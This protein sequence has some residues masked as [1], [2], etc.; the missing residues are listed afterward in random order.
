MDSICGC[1]SVG[2]IP[3]GASDPYALRRQSIGI[4]QI[5]LDRKFSFSLPAFIEKA[6]ALFSAVAEEAPSAISGK[7]ADFFIS[8]MTGLLLEAGFSRDVVSAVT[9]AQAD[10]VP[11]VW[12]RVRALEGLKAE[13]DFDP[14]A[15]A[16]KRVVNII[17]KAET[18][19]PESVDEALFEAPCEG[20]LYRACRAV[21]KQVKES[22]ASGQFDAALRQIASLRDV[23][24]AFF[25]G[26]LVMAEDGAIRANRLA[27]L[28]RISDLFAQ[29]ADF[30]K[31]ST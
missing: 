8:R 28:G 29:F 6:T 30:S 18:D 24:D 31:I 1:F 13:P 27:L 5:M 26:V 10:R 14:L 7:V 16:F 12:D 20:E 19:V 22:L 2:L 3:T 23:V 21:G 25:E 17:K 11:D 4:L 9:A 15:I